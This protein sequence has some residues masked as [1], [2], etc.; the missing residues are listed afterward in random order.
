MGEEKNLVT[1]GTNFGF[2]RMEEALG[3]LPTASASDTEGISEDK[4]TEPEAEAEGTET[5]DGRRAKATEDIK[6]KVA[7][8]VTEEDGEEEQEET[9]AED[10]KD[11]KKSLDQKKPYRT[12]LNGKDVDLPPD[13]TFKVPVDGKL[14]DVPLA[15]LAKNYTGK[16]V[17]EKKFNELAVDRKTFQK[18]QNTF[19]TARKQLNDNIN[20]VYKMATEKND[21][22]GMVYFI[23]ETMGAEPVKVWKDTVL[24]VAQA[25]KKAGIEVDLAALEGQF[26]DDEL[27]Y[28]RSAGQRRTEGEKTQAIAREYA[29]RTDAAMK[30]YGIP[31]NDALVRTFDE[32]K[33]SGKYDEADITPE[34]LGEYFSGKVSVDIAKK[35]V[36]SLD[37]EPEN[38]ERAVQ[39]IADTKR[40]NP[41]FTEA[42]L[43]AI[44]KE[45]F[46]GPG[47]VAKKLSNKVRKD[48]VSP[49]TRSNKKEAVTWDDVDD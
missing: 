17:Y 29:N 20:H 39:L 46:G 47:K 21:P 6:K 7:K 35:V 32:M 16:V 1:E 38:M 42:D 19:T 8:D 4:V 28:H 36:A 14:E 12:K 23:A 40:Q 22:R 34:A 11:K 44:A 31:D 24:S 30:K 5:D 45:V 33:A 2:D 37:E 3:G 49:T 26:K 18:E 41:D 25:M 15:E 10:P 9:A 43:T 13:T 48:R 27:E